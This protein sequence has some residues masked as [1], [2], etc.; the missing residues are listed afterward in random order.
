MKSIFIL[1]DSANGAEG[2][3]Y[4]MKHPGA[5][6][7]MGRTTFFSKDGRRTRFCLT[8]SGYVANSIK[9]VE[10]LDIAL[11]ARNF[12]NTSYSLNIP[13]INTLL[14]RQHY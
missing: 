3:H 2:S 10:C 8:E 4:A 14:N 9:Y 12:D 6:G 13:K 1:L 11:Y 5:Y 7:L